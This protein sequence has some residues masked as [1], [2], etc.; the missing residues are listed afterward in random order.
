MYLDKDQRK[1]CADFLGGGLWP[2]ME[3][4]LRERLPTYSDSNDAAE[5]AAHRAF[6]RKGYEKCMEDI[7]KLA[8]EV[9]SDLASL[10]PE[11][12]NDPRD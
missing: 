12:L 4:A 5:T 7:R 11:T 9:P 6:E 2:H 10:I 1:N 3:K 8:T